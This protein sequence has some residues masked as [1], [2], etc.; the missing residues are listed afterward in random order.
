MRCDRCVFLMPSLQGVYNCF[1]CLLVDRIAMGSRKLT[2]K[3][4]SERWNSIRKA[5]RCHCKLVG[6]PV[7]RTFSGAVRAGLL[8]P[9]TCEPEIVLPV[10]HNR[11]PSGLK[12]QTGETMC[13]ICSKPKSQVAWRS[14]GSGQICKACSAQRHKENRKKRALAKAEAREAVKIG[15]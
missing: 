6:V 5:L 8:S 13:R 15:Q 1:L 12:N 3:A 2:L 4:A 10:D 11:N 14:D 7:Q 9:R